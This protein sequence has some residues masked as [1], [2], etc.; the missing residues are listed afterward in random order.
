[1]SAGHGEALWDPDSACPSDRTPGDGVV[2]DLPG[3]QRSGK[4]LRNHAARGR[5]VG[6]VTARISPSQCSRTSCDVNLEVAFVGFVLAVWVVRAGAALLEQA[7]DALSLSIGL[8]ALPLVSR[9]AH[10]GHS[11]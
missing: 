8:L 5:G 3:N 7:A 9:V 10:G 11:S 6:G 1:M 2:G 4:S